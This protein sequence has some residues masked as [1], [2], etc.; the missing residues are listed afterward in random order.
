M[1]FKTVGILNAKKVNFF[2]NKI[3]ELFGV[4]VLLSYRCP[5][6][7]G[8]V[9]LRASERFLRRILICGSLWEV[10]KAWCRASNCQG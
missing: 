1:D 8:S 9:E 2:S 4:I 10:A 6:F 7:M 3:M 5:S